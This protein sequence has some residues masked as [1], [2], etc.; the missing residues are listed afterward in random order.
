MVI[1]SNLSR[2][3]DKYKCPICLLTSATKIPR[4]KIRRPLQLQRGEMFCLD[5]SFWSTPSIRGFTSILSAIYMKTR[6]SFTFLTRHKRPPLATITWFIT[7]LRRQ[8]YPIIY[9]QTDEGGKLGRSTD[10][11]KVLTKHECIYLGTGKTGS[12]LNGMIVRPNRTIA[13]SVRAK[14]LN[15]GLSDE[16]W[17]FAAEDANYKLRRMLHTAIHTTPYQAWT[18][19][20]PSYD[21]MKIWGCQVYI[22]NTDVMRTKLEH[23]THVGLFMKFASSTKI[24]VYYNPRTKKFGCTSHAYFD[25]LNIGMH[26][27]T[28]AHTPIPGTT[29]ISSFPQ[30]P[31]DIIL[32]DIKSDITKLPILHEPPVTNGIILPPFDYACP[33][34]FYD[35]DKYGLPY[36]K[37][38]P[39][40]T[41]IGQQLPVPARTQQWV[42]SIGT[43]E[44]IVHATSAHDEITR[45]RQTHANKKINI[46]LAPRVID[47]ANNYESQRT[48]FDQMRPILASVTP[49]HNHNHFDTIHHND[50]DTHQS[51]N[52]SLPLEMNHTNNMTSDTSRHTYPTKNLRTSTNVPPLPDTANDDIL[53]IDPAGFIVPTISVFVHSATKPPTSP[54]IQDC[55]D[56]T[57]PLGSFWIQTAYEQYD[58]NA[59]YRVFTRPI[60]KND[61]PSS[62]LILK[63]VLALTVKP[64]D[65]DNLWKFIFG[66]VS[67]DG[68]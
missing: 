27:L 34:K 63:S 12:S 66:I 36:V 13:N 67:M 39:A 44:P 23:R 45:L 46:T 7:T 53:L 55:F 57:N 1:P 40:S 58:K 11:L 25:E 64:T 8:G 38:I 2:F 10:F 17:C 24:I 54:N 43:E 49:S 3:H 21:N 14:L 61:I 30:I 42:L 41:P 35:D 50:N 68:P 5:Y 19:K 62:S 47:K 56:G 15:A 6:F 60:P 22:I 59:S 48:K 29:L 16:F 52:T 33:I 65:I 32:S 18:D 28:Y 31:N 20:V 37:H 9:I 4:T 26:N 51:A